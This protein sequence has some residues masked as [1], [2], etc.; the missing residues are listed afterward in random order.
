MRTLLKC[1][2]LG[3]IVFNTLSCKVNP[4]YKDIILFHQAIDNHDKKTVRKYIGRF[5]HITNYELNYMN[6]SSTHPALES[7]IVNDFEIMK[8]VTKKE[9]ALNYQDVVDGH[10]ALQMAVRHNN[11]EMVKYLLHKG[12]DPLLVD[13]YGQ[14]ILHEITLRNRNLDMAKLFQ[15]NIKDL[16]N[17]PNIDGNT[18]FVIIGDIF[19]KNI[20]LEFPLFW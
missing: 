5:K 20:G 4:S 13:K 15:K 11:M 8:I 10:F 1:L 9:T 6:I 12:A 3:V 16:V 18:P 14:S 7:A 19:P 2:M 17:K